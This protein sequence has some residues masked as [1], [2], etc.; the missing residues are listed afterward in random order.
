M[1][2]GT[3]LAM[4]VGIVVRVVLFVTRRTLMLPANARKSRIAAGISIVDF[5]ATATGDTHPP[6]VTLDFV[7]ASRTTATVRLRRAV[8]CLCSGDWEVA[9]LE[10]S[11]HLDP[12][13]A[14]IKGRTDT[15]VRLRFDPPV[16]WWLQTTPSLAIGE[17]YFEVDSL[18]GAVR[19]NPA[20]P[21]ATPPEAPPVDGLE[22]VRKS[23]LAIIRE[24]IRPEA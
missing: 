11:P 19:W 24:A 2:I 23:Y 13:P 18:W 16:A 1:E 20:T 17:A 22:A 4:L 21:P 14:E 3:I 8:L 9:R 12:V 6:S 7:I 5:R 10:L 15:G